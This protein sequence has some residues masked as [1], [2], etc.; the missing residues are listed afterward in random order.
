MS[1]IEQALELAGEKAQAAEVV[2]SE[3]RSSSVE[4]EDDKLKRVGAAQTTHLNVRVIVNGKLGQA[5]ATDPAEAEQTVARAIELAE[6]G[7]EAKFRFP[8]R[9]TPAAVETYDPAVE[10]ISREQMVAAGG[11]MLARLKAYNSEIKVSCGAGWSVGERRL[12]NS[13]GLDLTSRGSH[14]GAGVS[15]LWVRGT[16]MFWTG[17]GKDWRRPEVDPADLAEKSIRDFRWGERIVPV[18]T[19]EMPVIFTPRGVRVLLL[20]VLLGVNGRNVLKGDSPLKGK[21]GQRIAG[22]ELTLTDDPTLDYAPDSGRWDGEGVPRRKQTIVGEGVLSRFLYDLD[23]AAK[24]GT[25]STGNGPGCGT[26]NVVV[27][28]GA[29][30]FEEMVKSTQEGIIVESVLGLGQGNILNGDFSVNIAVGFKIEQGEIVGR[31][32]DVMLAGNAYDA[33]NRI[34]AIGSEPEWSNA[35]YAPAIKVADLS[36]VAKG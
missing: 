34:E 32:K 20:S 33:L 18:A 28:P 2:V 36:V 24:A 3:E 6:F 21:L 19:K 31:I 12:I 30:S 8:G 9:A 16:D 5:V 35:Q 23:T 29:T 17:R 4:Y 14:Y 7:S 27:T 10:A 26:T 13:S 15:G 1:L 25:E 22:P 11:E